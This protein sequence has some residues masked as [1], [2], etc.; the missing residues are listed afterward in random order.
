MNGGVQC[1]DPAP[2]NAREPHR[3][4]L[5]QSRVDALRASIHKSNR[6]P[7]NLCPKPTRLPATVGN[8]RCPD[9]Q[10]ADWLWRPGHDSPRPWCATRVLGPWTSDGLQGLM[11]DIESPPPLAPHHDWLRFYS[12][13]ATAHLTPDVLLPPMRE[14]QESEKSKQSKKTHESKKS[15][16]SAARNPPKPQELS[17]PAQERFDQIRPWLEQRLLRLTTT[18]DQ[19][20]GVFVSELAL[21]LTD[22]SP[23][24]R[25]F[26]RGGKAAVLC[27]ATVV[28]VSENENSYPETVRLRLPRKPAERLQPRHRERRPARQVAP[29]AP[30]Q[31]LSAR[32]GRRRPRRNDR[33]GASDPSGERGAGAAPGRAP[34]GRA[35]R[36][37]G[38]ARPVRLPPPA[39]R[40]SGR[41]GRASA[42]RWRGGHP[43][44]RTARQR[45]L[46]QDTDSRGHAPAVSPGRL[47][48]SRSGCAHDGR[49]RREVDAEP[50]R[51][52]GDTD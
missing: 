29:A 16:G 35:A 3:F 33:A 47:L 48:H 20:A 44:N 19:L 43:R 28:T 8:D 25:L 38:R 37:G 17:S 12:S 2:Q 49:R 4:S 9:H 34:Q 13:A 50:R 5:D 18:D 21:R 30:R 31:D 45:R 6:K 32:A 27:T 1:P 51:G 15:Q 39:R 22:P 36:A 7:E 11:R 41:R 46:R 23:F 14:H 40:G 24:W 42:T 52:L 10:Q 26:H